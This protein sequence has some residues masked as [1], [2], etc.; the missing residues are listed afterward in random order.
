MSNG[1]AAGGVMESKEWRVVGP[2]GSGK[3]TWLCRQAELALES[4]AARSGDAFDAP[5]GILFSSLTKAAAGELHGRGIKVAKEA[6]GTLHAHAWRS[7]G[8]PPLCVDAHGVEDW[9]ANCENHHRLVLDGKDTPDRGGDRTI[10]KKD[11]GDRLLEEYHLL[12]ARLIDRSLWPARVLEFAGPYE[13]WKR[14]A[15]KRDFSDVIHDA[16][17]T[18]DSAPGGPSIIFV[19]E[20]QDHDR[21]ELRLVRKWGEHPS[22][23]RLVVVGDPDQAIFEWRGAEPE[24][25]YGVDLPPERCRVL[26]KSWRL[27]TA[28][29]EAAMGM[30]RRCESRA[31]VEYEPRDGGPGSVRRWDYEI[32]AHSWAE[33]LV[34]RAL[35]LTGDRTAMFL[36]SCEY[37]LR[38]IVEALKAQG[39]A[40][41]NPLSRDRATFNP[42]HPTNGE[43]TAQRLLNFMRPSPDVFGENARVWTPA[44]LWSWVEIVHSDFLPRGNK[45]ALK[46]AAL[47]KDQ[48]PLSNAELLEWFGG[49]LPT[50]VVE[51]DTDWLLERTMSQRSQML[52]YALRI[53]RK[54]GWRSLLGNP[55][56]IVG[57][58]HSCKGGEAD[59]VFVCPDLSQQGFA[60]FQ[61]GGRGHDEIIRLFYVAMTRAREDLVLCGPS[62]SASINW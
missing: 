24:A 20:A 27:P 7:L 6:I 26:R 8:N 35:E 59:A 31:D 9:N 23:E 50:E 15:G 16:W 13:T 21:S 12:R 47:Q 44:E 1:T 39:I 17:A 53:A 25:F 61:N 52:M 11:A 42:L 4:I 18:V 5:G 40:F 3:T 48:R 30:I 38:P 41:W 43:S 32:F 34:R 49:E 14:L 55:H 60:Q 28:V 56:V 22:C 37:Q 36:A 58:I 45:T 46:T 54:S 2:P 57:T 51:L 29:H 19:D 62:G 10:K 33:Q